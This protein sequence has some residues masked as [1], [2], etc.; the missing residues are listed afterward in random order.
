MEDQA[1]QNS[2]DTT[3]A[4][5]DLLNGIITTKNKRIH[6]RSGKEP[7]MDEGSLFNQLLSRKR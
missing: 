5:K 3:S 6:S 7:S 1:E 2:R 4:C